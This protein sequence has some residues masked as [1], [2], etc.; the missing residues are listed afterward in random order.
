MLPLLTGV[1]T[2]AAGTAIVVRPENAALKLTIITGAGCVASVS[3]VD[4]PTATA[5]T[6]GVNAE[7]DIP[8]NTRE[9]YEVDWPYFRISAAGGSLRYALI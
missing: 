2:L 3:R 7:T 4:S 9:S 5:H 8:Q 1:Q 6:T